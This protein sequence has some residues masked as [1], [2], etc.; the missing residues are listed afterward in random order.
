MCAH[1]QAQTGRRLH[2]TAHG[3][4]ISGMKTAGNICRTHMRQYGG[5]VRLAFVG[6]KFADI[7]VEID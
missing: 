7:A 3:A 6:F 4:G 2:G 5:F 1:S